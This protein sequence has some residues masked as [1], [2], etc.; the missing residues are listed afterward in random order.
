MADRT[1]ATQTAAENVIDFADMRRKLRPPDNLT[2]SLTRIL[3]NIDAVCAAARRVPTD[4]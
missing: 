3:A 1:S 4:G 2:I